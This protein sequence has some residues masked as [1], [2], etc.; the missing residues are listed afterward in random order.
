MIDSDL[1]K[2]VL[3]LRHDKA[4]GIRPIART[5]GISR[6]TVREILEQG[7]DVVPTIEREQ[8]AL[9]YLDEIRDLYHEC[10]GNLVRVHEK[11]VEAH[12][13]ELALPYSTLTAFCRRQGIGVEP[14]T[15]KGRYDFEP[16]KETQQDTSPHDVVVGGRELRLQ[17]ASAVLCFSRRHYAQVYPTFESVHAP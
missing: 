11:L 4:M 9:P 14:P 12:R 5:L 8:L 15:P 3:R 16:G 10:R 6:N 17:C 7:S 1:R 2:A 13:G